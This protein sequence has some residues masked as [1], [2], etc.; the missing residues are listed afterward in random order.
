MVLG[1]D[2]NL[3]FTETNVYKIAKVT[4][5]G[6]ITEYPIPM[7][8]G[9]VAPRSITKGPDGALWFTSE[10]EVGRITTSGSI[11]SIPP[12]ASLTGEYTI[13]TGPDGNLYYSGGPNNSGLIVQQQT[14]GPYVRFSAPAFPGATDNFQPSPFG[15]AVGV[16]QG[17]WFTNIGF[18]TGYLGRMSTSGAF[19]SYEMPAALANSV[20]YAIVSDAASGALYFLA[21][22]PSYTNSS[23]LVRS[24]T[25]GSINIVSTGSLSVAFDDESNLLVGP[26]GNIWSST[27]YSVYS[28]PAAGGTP[29]FIGAESGPVRALTIGSD[30]NVWY[31][32]PT[33]NVVGRFNIPSTPALRRARHGSK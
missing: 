17:I 11:T 33:N 31:L 22:N 19:S 32:D 25:A 5:A 29:C 27:P 7:N 1:P 30:G 15:L 3:W 26:D 13:L 18:G 16:D 24:T 23:Y 6:A 21:S 9:N 28:V 20:S 10:A 2:G 14:S 8:N 4:P 12:G